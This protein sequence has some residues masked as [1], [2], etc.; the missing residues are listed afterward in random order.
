MIPSILTH[1]YEA[2]YNTLIIF[3]I[4]YTIILLAVLIDLYFGVQRARR[5]N[6]VRTSFGFRRTINKLTTYFGLTIMLSLADIV[7]SIIFK[8]PYFT[9]ITT[10]GVILVEAKSVLENIKNYNKN[11]TEK[12]QAAI[13]QILKNKDN[14]QDFIKL[15]NT[16]NQ[17]TP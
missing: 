9:I 14:I 4:L 5:L 6:I 8:F 2:I 11:D 13:M 16:A 7:T 1:N 15:T 12:L 3:T 17:Q 10:L